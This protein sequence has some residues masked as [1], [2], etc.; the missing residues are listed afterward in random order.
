[1]SI[2]DA[3]PAA[4]ASSPDAPAAKGVGDVRKGGWFVR[5]TIVGGRDH[6]A[7]SRP[8]AC[9]SR[10]S[11]PRRSWTHRMV[12]GARASVP[13]RRSG[14][15]RTTG[16]A[17]TRGL[18]ER[19]AQQ[20]RGHDPLDGDPDHDRG[21][22]GVRVL[23]DAVPRPVRAVRHRRGAARR[24]VA[25][26]AHPDPALYNGGATSAGCTSSRTW[27]SNGTFLGIWLAHTAFGLPLGDV[28][29]AELHRIAAVVDHRVGAD[30]RRRPLHDLLAA[31]SIPLSVPA[32]AAFAIFQFLW[33]WNDLL[34]AYVF[35]GGHRREPRAHGRACRNLVGARG[36]NWHLLTAAAFISMA[37]PLIVFF[38]L[39]RYFVRGLTAGSVKG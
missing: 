12:D 36:E 6:L 33:V 32:L 14:R 8:S 39:Q 3:D 22:R 38:S 18:L 28:P 34:V 10:R 11:D 35:L 25:D 5:I 30:R 4:E 21:V 16:A 17:S 37:L 7:R 24:A 20:P 27:T 26:G 2:A 9:W 29:P 13:A 23:V 1:M 31:R 15:S 19:V